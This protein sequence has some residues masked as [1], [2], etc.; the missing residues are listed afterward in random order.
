MSRA[1]LLAQAEALERLHAAKQSRPS[2]GGQQL[3][4]EEYVIRANGNNLEWLMIAA[5]TLR[6]QAAVAETPSKTWNAETLAQIAAVNP[7]ALPERMPQSAEAQESEPVAWNAHELMVIADLKAMAN[8]RA[9]GFWSVALADA[10]LKMLR[11]P[12]P[13]IAEYRELLRQAAT[14]CECVPKGVR[15]GDHISLPGRIRATLEKL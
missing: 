2:I 15:N 12:D 5:E 8:D 10:A 1:K 3:G 6:A 13:R 14:A 4:L 7:K 11:R 9:R